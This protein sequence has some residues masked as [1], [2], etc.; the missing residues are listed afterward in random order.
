LSFDATDDVR[1]LGDLLRRALLVQD[2]EVGADR[3]GELLVQLHAA[4][5]GRDD[6]EVV[7]LLILEPTA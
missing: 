2:R 1:D 6:H 7:H 5:V 4:G 3:R